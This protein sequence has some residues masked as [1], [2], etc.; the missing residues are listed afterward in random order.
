M[1]KAITLQVHMHMSQKKRLA[2]IIFLELFDCLVIAI[3]MSN[4]SSKNVIC[5]SGVGNDHGND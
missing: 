5:P 1:L 2:Q 4:F 3:L